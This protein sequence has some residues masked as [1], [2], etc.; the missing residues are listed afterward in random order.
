MFFVLDLSAADDAQ[1]CTKPKLEIISNN[2]F[3]RNEPGFFWLHQFANDIHIITQE[4]AIRNALMAFDQCEENLD[5]YEMERYLRGLRYLREA[6]VSKEKNHYKIQTWDNWTLQPNVSFGRKGNENQW[7]L[8]I[9]DDNIMG[10]GI[11]SSAKYQ[12]DAERTGFEFSFKAPLNLFRP[13]NTQIYLGKNDDGFKRGGVISSP[14]YSK[15]TPFA[16]E[17][18]VNQEE[19]Q[20]NVRKGHEVLAE[21][22]L[23]LN[24]AQVW[25]GWTSE[26][27][28]IT[29]SVKRV[30]VGLSYE[31]IEFS[32]NNESNYFNSRKSLYPWWEVEYYRDKFYKLR[33][34]DSVNRNED[35]NL[36]HRI[37]MRIGYDLE[38]S[39]EDAKGVIFSGHLRH[40][41]MS[42]KNWL[43]RL[44]VDARTK[45]IKAD[46]L[47]YFMRSIA[48]AFYTFHPYFTLYNQINVTT[49]RYQFKDNPVTLGA[50]EGLIAYPSQYAHGDSYYLLK[51]ELRWNPN[52]S[53]IQLVD[54]SGAFFVGSGRIIS[55]DEQITSPMHTIGF[56]IRFHS[57]RSSSQ[58]TVFLD[59]ARPMSKD[60]K[61]NQWD[62]RVKG[63]T[64]F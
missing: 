3:D 9:S 59:F 24:L 35:I 36:G 20:F 41:F 54:L 26:R 47:Q 17:F 32:H 18:S 58:S 45:Q 44:F 30:R 11:G 22:Q 2:V 10:L 56:G 5:P 37:L 31:S 28:A 48:E 25:F 19:K 61:L 43:F 14:F 12:V 64:Q 6:N 1:F 29:D 62:W 60:S 63:K 57:A 42:S 46:R 27:K 23:N 39:E 55:P 7:S 34:I 49:S 16:G 53:L 52:I 15:N 38:G 21:E 40:A 51:S 50:E 13:I 4:I 8:G 33:N